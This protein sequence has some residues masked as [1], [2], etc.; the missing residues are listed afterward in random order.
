VVDAAVGPDFQTNRFLYLATIAS[1]PGGQRTVSVVRVRELADRV[2]EPATLVA[3]LLA[4]PAGTPA[5]AIGPD[6][7]I[8]LAMPG[9]T[10]DRVEYGGHVLRFTPDGKA[11]GNAQLGSPVL[12]RGRA[13]PTRLAWDAASRLLMASAESGLA[14]GLAVVPVDAG[15]AG[16][17]AEPISVAATIAGAQHSG[18]SDLAAAPAGWGDGGMATL[19]RI[20]GD[21]GVLLLA[22]ITGANSP[23]MTSVRT[24]PLGP[25][26]PST[27][28]F[29]DNGDLFVTASRS[30][31]TGAILVRL[32]RISPQRRP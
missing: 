28:A 22:T 5:I 18:S 12:T 11:A 20:E 21:P 19:A 2:G 17:P 31:E 3:D 14:P 7:R 16:W 32:R 30:T 6:R 15:S 4:A 25:L 29:A 13:D 1:T 8:Y 23:E 26:T 10:D 24:I 27:V 9:R